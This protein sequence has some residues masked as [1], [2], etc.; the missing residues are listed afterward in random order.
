[1][2]LYEL[3]YSSLHIPL[4]SFNEQFSIKLLSDHIYFIETKIVQ[5]PLTRILYY[6]NV[7]MNINEILDL[8]NWLS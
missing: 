8:C 2:I 4:Y 7:S 1:M 5:I 6:N 3:V